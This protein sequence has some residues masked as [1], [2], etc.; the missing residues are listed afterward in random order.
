M[1]AH[2]RL[3]AI[4]DAPEVWH[5]T[6]FAHAAAGRPGQVVNGIIDLCFP[7]D[8]SRTKWIIADWKTDR[9]A[10]GSPTEA[11]YKEQLKIYT[12]GFLAT[13]L[14]H[15]VEVE[16][17]L[18]GPTEDD[19]PTWDDAFELAD[20]ALRPLLIELRDRGV[21]PPVVGRELDDG[22][23]VAELAWE[24]A[25]LAVVDHAEPELDV[26]GWTIFE[27]RAVDEPAELVEPI[28]AFF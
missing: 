16:P 28:E 7:T 27:L 23:V 11:I 18:I 1:L 3:A 24:D 6:P 12:E 14:E 17:V 9:P 13:W 15:P 4:R 5:E 26:P 8:A 21:P 22:R 25:R 20:P 10:P 19:G 2:P